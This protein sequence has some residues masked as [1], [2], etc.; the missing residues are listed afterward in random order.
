MINEPR[1]PSHLGVRRQLLHFTKNKLPEV[2]QPRV[3]L[4]FPRLG[5]GHRR[6]WQL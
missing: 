4:P 1:N 5:L 3:A 6:S 2:D